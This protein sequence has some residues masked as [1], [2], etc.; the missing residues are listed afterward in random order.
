MTTAAWKKLTEL[1][2]KLGGLKIADLV[3][4]NSRLADYALSTCVLYVDYS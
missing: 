4:D 3:G 1:S 2:Q